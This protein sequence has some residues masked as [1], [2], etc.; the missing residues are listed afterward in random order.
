[1]RKSHRVNLPLAM[2][3]LFALVAVCPAMAGPI[4]SIQQTSG[5]AS[6]NVSGALSGTYEIANV[7]DG[8]PSEGSINVTNDLDRRIASLTLYCD[9]LIASKENFDSQANSGFTGSCSI[10]ERSGNLISTPSKTGGQTGMG[11]SQGSYKFASTLNLHIK[12]GFSFNIARASFSGKA[13][14]GCMAGTASCVPAS[15]PRALTLLGLSLFAL[16]PVAGELWR[17]VAR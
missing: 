1:M 2:S 17:T 7:I 14:T 8:S 12:R 9:S 15:K 6:V 11:L 4:L 3:L 16:V 5:P 10:Y 13:D